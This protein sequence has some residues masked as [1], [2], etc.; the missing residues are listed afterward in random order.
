MTSPPYSLAL[1]GTVF[2]V[3]EKIQKAKV[4]LIESPAY[5]WLNFVGIS[6]RS[7]G[8]KGTNSKTLLFSYF[9]LIVKYVRMSSGRSLISTLDRVWEDLPK[10]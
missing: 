8:Q 4:P 1:I 6:A 9:P 3:G 5:K 2:N 7:L 10:A